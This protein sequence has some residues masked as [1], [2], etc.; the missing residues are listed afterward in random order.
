MKTLLKI[1]LVL[2]LISTQMIFAQ[3]VQFSQDFE[4][5]A[6]F[7]F[8]STRVDMTDQDMLLDVFE[9]PDDDFPN[10]IYITNTAGAQLIKPG[11]NWVNNIG[12][13][14]TIEG[15][16]FKWSG[17][18]EITLTG[19]PIDVTTTISL[20]AGFTYVSY[21]PTLELDVMDAFASIV[22]DNLLYVR[23]STGAMLR[24]I[25]PNW[26]N[27]IGNGIPTEGYLVKMAASDDLIYPFICGEVL[28]YEGTTYST[29][30]ITDGGNNTQCWMGENLNIGEMTDDTEDMTNDQTIEKYC[31]DDDEENCDVY[32]GLYQ[33][34]EA[35]QYTTSQGAQGI[36]PTGW[37]I[38][39]DDEWSDLE[40]IADTQYPVGDEEW[41]E[42]GWRG[43]NAG[44]HLKSTSGWTNGNG[45]DTYGFTVLPAG[46]RYDYG[47][48][49]DIGVWG[50][51][52]SSDENNSTTAFIREF[53]DINDDSG[54]TTPLKVAGKSIR[55]IQDA[56]D[57]KSSK[58]P[59]NSNPKL[60]PKHFIVEFGDPSM[61]VWTIYIDKGEFEKG[62]E[63]G[64]YYGEILAG[65][66]VIQSDNMLENAIPIFSNLYK[67]G[68][69]PIIKIWDQS[70]NKE[71]IISNYSFTNP[72]G[73]AYSRKAFPKGDMEYTLIT[74][75]KLEKSSAIEIEKEIT[76]SPN[77]SEGIF[78]ITINDNPGNIQLIVTDLQGK[79]CR[80]F[81]IIENSTQFDLSDLNA[82]IYFVRCIGENFNTV[83]KVVIK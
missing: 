8:T 56:T 79:V 3:P 29:V 55:C 48:S 37:H 14:V 6:G 66:G 31:V 77:P 20:D 71:Y 57:A 63:I 41:D 16:L 1:G 9:E 38:P 13:W 25:G 81:K 23:N 36:C 46:Q 78:N 10:L 33:W 67:T 24:K 59:K 12:D 83:K 50:Q 70:S 65:S 53:R 26:V 60:S 42:W 35:M 76:I 19:D 62:D 30:E 39:T 72:Y 68:N 61:D 4:W 44:Y 54:R 75:A 17:V 51:F 5:S 82:G 18:G 7:S 58:R 21:L 27:G 34:D 11:P 64:V 40:G 28:F 15:Y 43:Y 69:A 80:N 52:W 47:G 45:N 32:G 2:T 49:G 74:S 73:N 22:G